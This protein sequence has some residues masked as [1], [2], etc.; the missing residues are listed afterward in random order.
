MPHLEALV[1][2][3]AGRIPDLPLIAPAGGVNHISVESLSEAVVGAFDA[4]VPGKA[5]L[6]GDLNL[7]WKQYLEDFCE[8]AGNPVE[9]AVSEEEHPMFPDVMLYA[10]RNAV[11]EYEP[12]N[13]EL[14][15][16][17]DKVRPAMKA[18]VEAYL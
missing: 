8:L 18:V 10:G 16:S 6:V 15:Y 5:Y 1:Q 14:N 2:Y 13:G 9:L 7:S 4:G 17:R 12:D 3:V 11:I